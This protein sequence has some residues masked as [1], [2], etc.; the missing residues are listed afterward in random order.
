MA[1][2]KKL[3]EKNKKMCSVKAKVKHV[4]ETDLL[5]P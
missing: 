1:L 3:K 4:L 5:A 2:S